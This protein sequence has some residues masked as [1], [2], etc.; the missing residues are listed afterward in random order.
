MQSH[1]TRNICNLK[2]WHQTILSSWLRLRSFQVDMHT[3]SVWAPRAMLMLPLTHYTLHDIRVHITPLDIGELLS[4]FN[5]A[6]R[7]SLS[8]PFLLCTVLLAKCSYPFCS[9][10]WLA[11]HMLLCCPEPVQSML[12]LAFNQSLPVVGNDMH[13][14]TSFAW[15]K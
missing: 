6:V 13:D 4:F 14:K 15:V 3:Q 2:P 10:L 1:I 12:P 7:Y 9:Q 5:I 11:I 8:L